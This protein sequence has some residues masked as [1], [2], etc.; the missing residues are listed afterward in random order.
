MLVEVL[1]E[2]MQ[3]SGCEAITRPY[4]FPARVAALARLKGDQRSHVSH[5]ESLKLSEIG[6]GESPCL[7]QEL[8][9]S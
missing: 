1:G 3:E 2:L 6:G 8:L 5:A 9:L 4:W 7:R